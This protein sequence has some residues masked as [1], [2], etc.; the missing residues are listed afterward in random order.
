MPK[1][2]VQRGWIGS[3]DDTVLA[4]MAAFRVGAWCRGGDDT[5]RV[6]ARRVVCDV[7]VARCAMRASAASRFTDWPHRMH[8]S[9]GTPIA[10]RSACLSAY[11]Y[12]C[13][14]LS[15]CLSV[16]LSACVRAC[17]HARARASE[18]GRERVCVCQAVCV[19]AC[20]ARP[21]TALAGR[22]GAAQQRSALCSGSAAALPRPRRAAVPRPTHAAAARPQPS[23]L[24]ALR[25][26][27]K[28][29]RRAAVPL[30]SRRAASAG[31]LQRSPAQ[32]SSYVA[33]VRRG[34]EK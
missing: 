4:G 34:T 8:D 31:V 9:G 22:T 2:N 16:G 5:C 7:H 10:Y 19:R 3:A 21:A 27:P 30:V 17:A 18:R 33:H 6:A 23:R 29:S 11:L 13:P 25:T 32:V 20:V 12:L 14:S 15:L 1:Q 28:D 24:L 26:V